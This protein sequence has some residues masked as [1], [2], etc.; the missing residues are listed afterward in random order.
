MAQLLPFQTPPFSRCV[1][2]CLPEQAVKIEN[3]KQV[4]CYGCLLC[5]EG[6]I[7]NRTGEFPQETHQFIM[8]GSGWWVGEGAVQG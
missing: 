8:A 1:K 2:S 6:T 3:D 7:S 4:C 5:P